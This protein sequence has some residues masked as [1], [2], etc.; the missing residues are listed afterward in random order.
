MERRRAGV[1]EAGDV[2][3][4]D[5]EVALVEIVQAILIAETGDLGDRKSTRL[6]SSHLGIS[7]AVFCLKKKN[8]APAFTSLSYGPVGPPASESTQADSQ[9]PGP[10]LRHSASLDTCP[11]SLFRQSFFF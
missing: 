2:P 8:V 9:R 5:G 4:A 11:S 10:G 7:Y 6:N 1:A 3:G